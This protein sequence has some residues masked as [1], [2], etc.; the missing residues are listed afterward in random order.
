[1][2]TGAQLVPDSGWPCAAKCFIVAMTCFL[3][4][5]VPSP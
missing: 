5:N 4:R 2:L 3:S 1:M